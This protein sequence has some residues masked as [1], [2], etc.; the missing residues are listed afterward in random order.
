MKRLMSGQAARRVMDERMAKEQQAH[1]LAKMERMLL[2]IRNQLA[3]SS[4]G[5]QPWRG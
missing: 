5:G 2:E 1:R 3:E 4:T